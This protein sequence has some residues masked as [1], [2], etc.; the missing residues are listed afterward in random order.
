LGRSELVGAKFGGE[1]ETGIAAI[2]GL[3]SR[4][5]RKSLAAAPESDIELRQFEEGVANSTA[6]VL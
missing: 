3:N 2:Y 1:S 4:I 5:S 6:I